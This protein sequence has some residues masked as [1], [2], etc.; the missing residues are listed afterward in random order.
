M[1]KRRATATVSKILT[2]SCVDG[3]GNRLVI[4]LQ[5]CN[6]Q[7]KNCHNPHTIGVCN[8]CGDCV[9]PCPSNALSMQKGNVTW[10][11]E[12]C[13]QC[14][15]C[16]EVCPNQSNPKT[17]QM[18]VED[19]LQL[20]RKHQLFLSGITISGGEAT[21]Q[22]PFIVELFNAI[23]ADSGLQHLTCMVDSNGSLSVTGW[24]KLLPVLD[25]AMI[26][27][28]A[29]QEETH[30]W[31]TGRSHHRVIQSIK[32]LSRHDKLEEVRLLHIPG[33]TDF[34]HEID[35]ISH[36][37]ISLPERTVIRLN[38]F[39]HHGVTGQALKWE[40]CNG[41]QI[42][43]FAEQLTTRGLSVLYREPLG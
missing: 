26:D 37:L 19:I 18:G 15:R 31:L 25:G 33:I 7:C 8:D 20:V 10:Q 6:Y 42:K 29:W 9:A 40:P 21:L 14:D 38:A 39:Q 41:G 11:A 30:L 35:A 3:P 27:L 12:L 2:F 36:Y 1:S 34:E 13:T 16:L 5:G 17:Q 22:L 24:E 32:L 4:F 43:A 23:K 28:K